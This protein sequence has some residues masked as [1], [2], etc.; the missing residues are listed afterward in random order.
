MRVRRVWTWASCERT[1]VSEIPSR[2][3]RSAA[4]ARSEKDDALLR[5]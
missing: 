5:L 4:A 3:A 2:T 1:E